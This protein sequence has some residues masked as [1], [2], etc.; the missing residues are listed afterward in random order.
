MHKSKRKSSRTR[1]A[2]RGVIKRWIR[3]NEYRYH[4]ESGLPIGVVDPCT[5][6][7]RHIAYMEKRWKR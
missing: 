7:K 2:Q 3:V 5:K 1:M 4:R 6:A